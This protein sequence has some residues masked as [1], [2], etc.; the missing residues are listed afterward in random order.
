MA[1]LDALLDAALGGEAFDA[2]DVAHF[3]FSFYLFDIL[4]QSL[5]KAVW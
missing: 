3:A 4:P 1:L 5:F 2:G